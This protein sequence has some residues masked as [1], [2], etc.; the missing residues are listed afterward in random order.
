MKSYKEVGRA[1]QVQ[2]LG[3]L[4]IQAIIIAL[5]GLGTGLRVKFKILKEA[6]EKIAT[7]QKKYNTTSYKA[8]AFARGV[9]NI[10]MVALAHARVVPK[11]MKVLLKQLD[12]ERAQQREL[13]SFAKK[14]RAALDMVQT[15]KKRGLRQHDTA[16]TEEDDPQEKK[17]RAATTNEDDPQ[18]KKSVRQL[19][20]KKKTSS[21]R[22]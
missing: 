6:I 1:Q 8:P 10:L 9:A 20:Q 14:I 4:K 13:E 2:A 15:Q 18:K 11:R 21:K 17:R 22:R 16:T 12:G 7:E 19:R 5:G 3:L